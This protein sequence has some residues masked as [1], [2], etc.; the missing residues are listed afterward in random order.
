MPE[1]LR[2]A[3]RAICRKW[4]NGQM[5]PRTTSTLVWSAGA[6]AKVRKGSVIPDHVFPTL[7]KTSPRRSSMVCSWSLPRFNFCFC[8]L[9]SCSR[10]ASL[11][12]VS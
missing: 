3:I 1:T 10:V 8:A 12:V 11:M 5:T 2:T 7:Q 9:E 4:R 6:S